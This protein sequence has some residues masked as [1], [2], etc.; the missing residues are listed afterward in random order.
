MNNKLNVLIIEDDVSINDIEKRVLEKNGF[1]VIQA[2]SGSEGLLNCQSRKEEIDIIIMDLFLPGIDGYELLPQI[3]DILDVP[4]IVVS[5]ISDIVDKVKLLDAGANDYITKPFDNKEL[6]AR[7]GVQ[8]R[9]SQVSKLDNKAEN[10]ENVLR[11]RDLELFPE[12]FDVFVC[13]KELILTKYEFK[14]LELFLKNQK[15]IFSKQDIY[16]IIWGEIYTGDDRTIS[17]HISN[18]RKK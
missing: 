12:T 10:M 4:V 13:G 14:I 17:V 18:I 6:L 16:E 7:I 11:Y 3:K 15:R 1:G 9:I 2:Y 5:A 8:A